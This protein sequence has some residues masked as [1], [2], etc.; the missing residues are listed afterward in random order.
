VST[1]RVQTLGV[2]RFEREALGRTIQYTPPDRWEDDSACEGWRNRDVIAHLAATDTAAAAVLGDEVPAEVEEY[3]KSREEEI[4]IPWFSSPDGLDGFNEFAVGRRRDR[5]FRQV[6]TE[7]GQAANLVL[8]RASATS[9]GDWEGKRVPWV[10]SELPIRFLVQSRISEWWIHGEDIRAGAGL[11]ARLEHDPIQAVNDLAIRTIPY[12]LG[13]AGISYPGRSVRIDLEGAGG[14]IWHYGLAP[15]E[16]PGP[17]KRPDAWIE[18]RAYPFAL[19][20]ARRVPAEHYVADGTFAIGGDEDI[21]LDV[22]EHVRAI[23]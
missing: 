10:V 22:L 17:G 19:V 6:A 7:W 5:P 9:R 21:A 3:L 23:A 13:V 20:A 2:A 18:G 16:R 14:G 1:S 12:A 8:I 4:E 11:P 15:R